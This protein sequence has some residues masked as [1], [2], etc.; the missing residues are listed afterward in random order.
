MDVRQVVAPMVTVTGTES[1]PP[2][3]PA[4]RAVISSEISSGT[5][6]KNHSS[7]R[8]IHCQRGALNAYR[9]DMVP[10]VRS[11]RDA[12]QRR[13][14]FCALSRDN[15]LEPLIGT[16]QPEP[17]GLAAPRPGTRCRAHGHLAGREVSEAGADARPVAGGDREPGIRSR[18]IAQ[19]HQHCLALPQP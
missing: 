8:A 15:R 14:G 16:W 9:A 5:L 6:T 12:V 18:P 19:A 11:A 7:R 1:N 4:V 13:S 17:A 2:R 10:T 3:S